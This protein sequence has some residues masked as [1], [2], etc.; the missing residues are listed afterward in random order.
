MDKR[1]RGGDAVFVETAESTIYTLPRNNPKKYQ[2][3]LQNDIALCNSNS[4]DEPRLMVRR[5][6]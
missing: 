1:P 4:T 5:T 6:Q 3:I 2:I